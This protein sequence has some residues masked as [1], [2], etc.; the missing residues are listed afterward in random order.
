M[1]KTE[2]RIKQ[3][4]E[5][6]I[7]VKE[8][9]DLKK[10]DESNT[11]KDFILPL[12]EALGWDVYDRKEVTAEAPASRG[13]VDFAFRIDGIPKFFLETKALKV[14]LDDPRW[15]EQAIDYAWHKGVIWA[16]L[17][18]FEKIK[19]FNAE[20][21]GKTSQENLFFEIDWGEYLS[22]IGQLKLLS[23]D[24]FL[25]NEMD[26]EA[27]KWGKKKKKIP[28]DK[29]LLNDLMV[30]RKKLANSIRKYPRINN[31]T[32]EEMDECIQR[33][34]DRLIFIRTCEDRQIESPT[35]IS[36]VREWQQRSKGRFQ[37][38]LKKIFRDFDKGYNSKIFELH[39]SE[40][41]RIDDEVYIEIIEGLYETEDKSIRYDFSAID[42]DVL[43]SIINSI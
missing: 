22:R 43:G 30:W 12:F 24:A 2:D 33:I 6:Y 7:E 36:N 42:A 37:E 8:S 17:S 18:D 34:L 16:V 10:Y 4:V 40:D 1:S 28:V 26:K 19:V 15:V 21:L 11:R 14:N 3:L 38:T 25:D 20:W 9:G 23:K 35:L 39:I 5:K 41:L 13:K 27:T 31:L 32:E 29:K